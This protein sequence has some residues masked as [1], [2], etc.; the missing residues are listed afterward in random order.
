M[1][2]AHDS[3]STVFLARPEPRRRIV[4]AQACDGAKA[5]WRIVRQRG[6]RPGTPAN[7]SLMFPHPPRYWQM[8]AIFSPAAQ[9]LFD[10]GASDEPFLSPPSFC[11]IV[12]LRELR[13]LCCFFS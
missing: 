3:C 6:V 8:D 1:R 13:R 7:A 12:S 11:P 2:E 9:N 10:H 4:I 5:V